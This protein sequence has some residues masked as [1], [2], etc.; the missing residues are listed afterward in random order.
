LAY[1]VLVHSCSG[2]VR[3]FMIDFRNKAPRW[4]SLTR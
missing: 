2:S 3:W 4:P 1:L